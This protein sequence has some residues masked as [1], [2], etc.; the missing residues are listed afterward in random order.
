MNRSSG[1]REPHKYTFGRGPQGDRQP[2]NGPEYSKRRAEIS[3]YAGAASEESLRSLKHDA[4]AARRNLEPILAV[5]R[6]VLPPAG[7]V[8]EIASG[9]GQ[10]IVAFARTYPMLRWLPSDPDPRSRAS[11]AAWIEATGVAGVDPPRDVDVT[12][13]DWPTVLGGPLDAILCINLLHI[14]PWSACEGLIEGAARLLEPGA[15]LYL[16]GAFKREGRHTAPSNAEFDRSLRFRNPA[17][18][19]RDLEVVAACAEA[20]GLSLDKV[21]EMPAN[22][23]SVVLRQRRSPR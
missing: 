17:W 8:L 19:V 18:G 5:L 16:Y 1:L 6:G 23:L 9:T 21:V 3:S 15:P 20:N 13:A 2:M 22:N 7:T 12:A 14:S 11:I 4:P 10:H